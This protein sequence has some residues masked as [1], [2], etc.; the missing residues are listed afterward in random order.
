MAVDE[1]DFVWSS[2]YQVPLRDPV[3]GSCGLLL[4]VKHHSKEPLEEDLSL[5]QED[6]SCLC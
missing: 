2:G 5:R 3:R 4:M 6:V 1:V